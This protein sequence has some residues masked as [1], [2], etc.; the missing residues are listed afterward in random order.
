MND[1]IDPAFD[2]LSK[3]DG[4]GHISI[5]LEL[6]PVVLVHKSN[7]RSVNDQDYGSDAYVTMLQCQDLASIH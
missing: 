3:A 2:A 5:K 6:P 4:R 1:G 7:P